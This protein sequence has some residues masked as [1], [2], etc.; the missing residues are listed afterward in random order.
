MDIGKIV[1][2][3]ELPEEEPIVVPD[4][5]TAPVEEPVPEP[6]APSTR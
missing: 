5:S 6:A 2:E 4:P 1:R 3:V